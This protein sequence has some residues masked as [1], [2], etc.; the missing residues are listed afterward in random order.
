MRKQTTSAALERLEGVAAEFL[1]DKIAEV[2]KAQQVEVKEVEVAV[3][4]GGHGESP[5][6]TVVV[7]PGRS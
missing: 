5:T 1:E 6:V 2:Q 3:V 7:T 4:Q